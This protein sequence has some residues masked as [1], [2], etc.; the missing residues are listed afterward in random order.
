[1]LSACFISVLV[2]RFKVEDSRLV[3][4][5]EV[6]SIPEELLL[7]QGGFYSTGPLFMWGKKDGEV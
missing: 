6:G 3:G 5:C 4:E 2:H 7:G 1:V